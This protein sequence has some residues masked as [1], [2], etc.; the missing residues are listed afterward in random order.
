MRPASK[1]LRTQSRHAQSIPARPLGIEPRITVLETVVLPLHHG[2]IDPK[3]SGSG[4]GRT[5]NLPVQTPYYLRLTSPVASP[6]FHSSP[7]GIGA[8]SSDWIGALI[9]HCTSVLEDC[10]CLWWAP[11]S[12][13]ASPEHGYPAGVVH[14]LRRTIGCS[15]S[16]AR[17]LSGSLRC[18]T[19][20]GR[21][22]PRTLPAVFDRAVPVDTSL[23][24]QREQPQGRPKETVDDPRGVPVLRPL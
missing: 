23:H 3:V 1:R 16:R 12:P 8:V 5:C 9:G 24:L 11:P 21:A 18:L 19:T 17:A 15:F 2:R 22:G 13:F 7:T 4:R 10:T 6:G 14:D 20:S